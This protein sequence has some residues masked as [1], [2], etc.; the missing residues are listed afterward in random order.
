MND[1]WGRHI[2]CS[3]PCR[4]VC[5]LLLDTK[6]NLSTQTVSAKKSFEE[7]V[8]GQLST[9]Y[10]K[11][12]AHSL[13]GI[14]FHALCPVLASVSQTFSDLL[15]PICE[16]PALIQ[17]QLPGNSP[18]IDLTRQISEATERLCEMNQHIIRLCQESH[19]TPIEVELGL[20]AREVLDDLVLQGKP[21]SSLQIL[22]ETD[23]QPASLNGPQDLLYHLVRDMCVH[24]FAAMEEG[25]TLAI[26]V[27]TV[28]IQT[29]GVPHQLGVPAREY[30][31]IQFQDMTPALRDAP[32]G[33]FDPFS[34][35][36]PPN[37]YGLRLSSVY[38]SMLHFRG[39]ILYKPGGAA[40]A[41]YLLFFPK[42]ESP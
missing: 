2:S 38:R 8:L 10:R 20:L 34:T 30:R 29:D 17:K 36:C 11:A 1:S 18:A 32:I 16:Y 5:I 14:E 35:S 13:E 23:G 22:L 41:D 42:V 3:D 25:G 15:I 33:R 37:E 39:M 6:M 31:C 12:H 28:T 26:R 40:G 9:D 21:S 7:R 27:G 19:E 24:A 4:S